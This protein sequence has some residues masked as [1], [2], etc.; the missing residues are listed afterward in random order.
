MACRKKEDARENVRELFRRAASLRDEQID[1]V[2]GALL[3]AQGEYAK[4]DRAVYRLRVEE[5]SREAREVCSNRTG[6]GAGVQTGIPTGQRLAQL[7]QLFSARWG[8]RSEER[9]VG[10][11]CRSRWSPD[12]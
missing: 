12:H 7:S 3:I 6:V 2:E 9:R 8:F 4:L 1:L 5:M 11:E 10:K